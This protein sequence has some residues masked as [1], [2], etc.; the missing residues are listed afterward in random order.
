MAATKPIPA[1]RAFEPDQRQREAIEH[2]RGPMLVVA[3]AGTGKTTVLTRRI[4]RLV[5]DGHARPNEILAVTY[6][7][8]AVQE[9]RERVRDGL[10]GTDVSGLQIATFHEY[11]ND[12]LGRYGKQ[13]D[14]LDDQ[15]L[16]IYLRRRI[17]ELHLNYFVRAA[18]V[19]QFLHDLLGFMRRCQDDLVDPKKYANYVHQLERGEATIPRVSKSKDADDLSDQ[20]VIGRCQ[21]IASVFATVERMLREDNLGTFGHMITHAHALLEGNAGLLTGERQR[22]R[23]ILADEFQDVNF[24]QVKILQQLA[25]EERNVFAVGDPD[26][27]IYRFRGASSAAFGLFQEHFPEA[28]TVVLEKNRRSTTTILKSAFA[29]ISRNPDVF[30]AAQ[31]PASAYHRSPLISAREEE[32]S[33]DGRPLPSVPVD[34]VVLT[35]KEVECSDLVTTIRDRQRKLRCKWSDFAILYRQH[36]HREQIVAELVEQGIPFAIENMDVM[37]TPEARD[38]FASLGAIVSVNDSASLFRVAAFPPFAIDPEKLR[39]GI[40][41]IPREERKSGVASVLAKIENGAAVLNALQQVRDD[42]TRA[43]T[44]SS[45]VLNIIIRQFGL[46]RTSPAIAAVLEFVKKW[47]EKPRA[48]TKT[49]DIGEFI[50]YLQYF[51][52]AGGVIPISTGTENAVRLMTAH[53]AKGLEFN[54]VFIIRANSNSFPSSY[55]EPLVDFPRELQGLG[56]VPIFDDKELCRQEERR[57]FYVA[58]T[59]ARDS[60][61]I[62]ARQGRGKKDLTPDGF[63]RDLLKDV[64]LK[65]W[66][67]QRHALEFQTDLFAEAAPALPGSAVSEWLKL[68]P[69]F[70]LGARL[71]ASALQTY[72][73]CPLQ[74]KLER[75][76]RIPGEVPAAMEYGATIHRILLAYYASVRLGRTIEDDQ[77]IELFKT[78]LRAAGIEEKY[79]QELYERQGIEQLREFLASCKR[80]PVPQ[81]LHTE[82]G[83]E[84]Q[85]GPAKVVGRIDRIDRLDNGRVV[86]TDYKTGRPKSQ[87]DADKSLQLSIYALA[88]REKWGYHA[89]QIV[90]YNL[91]EN[92]SVVTRRSDIQLQECKT[93][94]EEVARKI[95]AEEFDAKPGFYCSF[96]A[97]RSLCPATEKRLPVD[98]KLIS[99]N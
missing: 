49:G 23:F 20:D 65:P 7:K 44:T 66:L 88:A 56:S 60:L 31:G 85:I 21:E 96:C 55:K 84:M 24:A 6:T 30:P 78:D 38:L 8:N 13:F 11:C 94:V 9:M 82:E 12:L 57:L 86:I 22:T 83:F 70:D 76:W 63:L 5:R 93:K 10:R 97:Y 87:E 64:S 59:R 92:S 81:V 74:F 72:E 61:T 54:H 58:M 46:N 19:S 29:L 36:F 99:R 47:E 25:G 80:A 37:D 41:A 17:P 91:E 39:A 1:A 33:R 40:R 53:V 69:A 73:I 45:G 52:T 50:D 67:R 34:A 77:L 3:G 98:K 16:W 75:E 28:K 43:A 89:D 18:N 90:F 4:A 48:I 62:Y 32:A 2:V 68:P 51:R 42:V 26:Q 35:A 79:Q 15:D 71:S 14:V 27:A 95:A